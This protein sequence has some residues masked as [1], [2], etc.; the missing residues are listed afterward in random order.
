MRL[1]HSLSRGIMRATVS[2]LLNTFKLKSRRSVY[3]FED[4]LAQYIVV[5]EHNGY[6][7]ELR[8]IAKTWMTLYFTL[9][10]P[11]GLKK[12]PPPVFLNSI[13]KNVW[14]NLGLMEDYHLSKKKETLRVTT[15]GEAGTKA[16]GANR[17]MVGFH[18]GLLS[19]L[20]K[21]PVECISAAQDKVICNYIFEI[22][23]G[24]FE[25][26]GKEKMVYDRLNRPLHFKGLDL[27]DAIRSNFVRLGAD[28]RMRLRGRE[29]FLVENTIFHLFGNEGIL[30]D[31][32][33]HVSHDF[34]EHLISPTSTW[35]EKLAFLKN[36]LQIMGW[37]IVKIMGEPSRLVIEINNPPHGLQQEKDNWIFLINTILGYLWVIDRGFEVSGVRESQKGFSVTYSR[38]G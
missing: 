4:I 28:N 5:C 11:S 30:I 29:F 6:E 12:L 10:V 25:V 31:R 14:A 38:R 19:V 20:Y 18:E 33:P 1:S 7:K 2:G 8:E 35:E 23:D 3:F 21:S 32:V 17:F 36:L 16:A 13:A 22:K 34:F 24:T 27:K 26:R 9:L 15:R 37:G